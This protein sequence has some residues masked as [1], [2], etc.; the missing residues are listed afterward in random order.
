MLLTS[1]EIDAQSTCSL[2][3]G[4]SGQSEMRAV[5]VSNRGSQN[6]FALNPV[7]TLNSAVVGLLCSSDPMVQNQTRLKT[8]LKLYLLAGITAA[9]STK[10]AFQLILV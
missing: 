7:S 5:W 2:I 6:A 9:A 10:L 8:V 1:N 4:L 3:V